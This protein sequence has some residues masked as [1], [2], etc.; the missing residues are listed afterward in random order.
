M[1]HTQMKSELRER[2]QQK[3]MLHSVH[4]NIAGLLFCLCITSFGLLA[5]AQTVQI[6]DTLY[7][8]DGSKD[9]KSVV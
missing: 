2:K 1:D 4:R 7:N 9:R 8:A 3:Q 5:E 6:L